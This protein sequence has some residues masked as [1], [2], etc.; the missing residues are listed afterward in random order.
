MIVLIAPSYGLTM[1]GVGWFLCLVIGS[2][3]LQWTK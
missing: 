3:H 2:M 1:L